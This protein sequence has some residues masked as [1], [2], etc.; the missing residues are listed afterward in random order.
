MSGKAPDRF[1]LRVVTSKSLLIET[2]ADEA[3]IPTI[4]G[5]IGVFPNH[6]PLIVALGRGTLSYR[7]AAYEE[8]FEIDGGYA[9]IS[10][11][12]VLVFTESAATGE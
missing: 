3:Q 10:P 9:E 5:L 8:R 2:D 4:D 12:S 1:R 7:Q 11:D 6:Q